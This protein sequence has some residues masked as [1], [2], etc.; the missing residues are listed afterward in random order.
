VFLDASPSARETTVSH[1]ITVATLLAIPRQQAALRAALPPP[2][3]LH[4]APDTAGLLAILRGGAVDLV[5]LDPA[6]VS[7]ALATGPTPVRSQRPGER[8]TG[9]TEP[10]VSP[11]AG[12]PFLPV[13]FYVASPPEAVRRLARWPRWQPCEVLLSGRDDAPGTIRDAITSAI[14]MG[15]AA[16]FFRAVYAD[17]DALPAA[18]ARAVR[19]AFLQPSHVTDASTV[20]AEA[21]MSR[22][23]LDRWLAREGLA[24]AS[25]LLYAV[26]ALI[27]LRLRRD[28]FLP[29]GE[30]VEACGVKSVRA[31]DAL[32][33]HGTGAPWRTL[34]HLDDAA[35][36]ARIAERLRRVTADAASARR[37]RVHEGEDGELAGMP[38]SEPVH[39]AHWAG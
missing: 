30:I 29:L 33:E 17:L 23:T 22:R 12:Y 28:A 32:I 25:D 35:L 21:C 18:L 19:H 15:I 20:A 9:R 13:V 24:S 5:V 34:V 26:R 6:A 37:G 16:Q 11:L 39:I 8:G 31:L 4:H 2:Q 10:P 14:K 27:A 38:P 36:I 3:V 1:P 7:P